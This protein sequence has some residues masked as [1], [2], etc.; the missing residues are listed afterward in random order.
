MLQDWMAISIVDLKGE[1]ALSQI[2]RGLS[3]A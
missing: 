3:L 1:K 2:S